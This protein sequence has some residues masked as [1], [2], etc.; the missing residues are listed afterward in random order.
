[1]D[2]TNK[3]IN[4]LLSELKRDYQD[5]YGVYLFGSRARG[6]EG[7]NSDYDLAVVFN[8]EV[9]S[10]LKR[11]VSNIIAQIMMKYEVII[12][13]PILNINDIVNPVTPLRQNIKNEG[14]FY[15]ATE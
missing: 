7:F 6:D 4:E 13:N 11:K 8:K 2:K 12:D 9:D 5:F 14:I 1:M 15:G 10:Q 3:I